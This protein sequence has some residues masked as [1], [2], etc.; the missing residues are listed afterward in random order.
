MCAMR[1]AYL[2]ICASAALL[3]SC[4]SGSGPSGAH[5]C[6]LVGCSDQLTATLRDANGS[7]PS[8]MQ[9][10]TVTADGATT[11]CSFTLPLAANQSPQCPS[12]LLVLV[13][14]DRTCVT[15]GDGSYMM[16]TC[17]PVPGKFSE[18]IMLMSKPAT[19]HFTATVDG[20]T[21]LDETVTPTYVTTQPNGPGC[22]PICS[23]AG[24]SLLLAP[25]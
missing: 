20:T 9:T 17:T 15:T 18:Q 19:V 23:Q 5:A 22:D 6:T 25:K 2:S 10:L 16:Q 12:P 3:A 24:V 21:Y 4:G 11:M 13:I 1:I 14:Q 8:G 7:L